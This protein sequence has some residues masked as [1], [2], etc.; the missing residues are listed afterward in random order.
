[1]LAKIK[2][3]SIPLPVGK[4]A[5]KPTCL[6][7]LLGI[8]EAIKEDILLKEFPSRLGIFFWNQW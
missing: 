4:K 5:Q 6:P 2:L 1:M 7:M 8:Y 3:A